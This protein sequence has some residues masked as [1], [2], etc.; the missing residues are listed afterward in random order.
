MLVPP[1]APTP[2]HICTDFIVLRKTAYG[3]TSVIASG[4]A[5][6]LGLTSVMVRGDR[7]LGRKS[8]PCV[9]LFRHLQLQLRHGRGELYTCSNAELVADYSALA[10][11]P[12]CYRAA[13]WLAAFALANSA[14]DCE[15]CRT[16]AATQLALRR[17]AAL[18]DNGAA[19]NAATT[20]AVLSCCCA[21]FAD[22]AG[23][24][25]H[26]APNSTAEQQRQMLIAAGSGQCRPAPLSAAQWL[27]LWQWLQQLL[28]QAD[29]MLPKTQI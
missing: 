22:D 17:F 19:V 5:P 3:D 10:Q 18:A 25:P 20:L 4:L 13:G 9:D 29:F 7:K 15:A 12:N 2:T 1:A 24:L 28:L 11:A 26:Y 8:F 21:V 16:F 27:L 14:A 6:E 23:V